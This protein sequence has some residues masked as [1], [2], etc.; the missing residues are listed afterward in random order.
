[1]GMDYNKITKT[2]TRRAINT[3]YKDMAALKKYALKYLDE[4]WKE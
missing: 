3:V 1:M 2:Q 4:V